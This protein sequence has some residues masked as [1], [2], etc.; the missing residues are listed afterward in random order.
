MYRKIYELLEK[1]GKVKSAVLLNGKN[2]GK[3]TVFSEGKCIGTEE[4]Q[5]LWEPY[6]A[7]VAKTEETTIIKVG[8]SEIFVEVYL[9]N[10]RLVILGAGHVS[11]PVAKIGKML[12][13]HI[14]VMDDRKEFLNRERFPDADVFICG[15]FEEMSERIPPYENTYY[16]VVTRGHQGDTVCARQILKRPH[17]YFGMIGSRNKVRLA[18][19]LLLQEGFTEEQLDSVYA[20]IGLPIGGQLPEEIAVSIAAQIVQVKNRNY[21]AFTDEKIAAAVR[22]GK[23]GIMATIIQKSGSSPRGIGSKMLICSPKECYGSI[24]GGS[25]EYEATKEA[26]SVDG[27]SR[28]YYNLSINDEKNLGMIC[29]GNVEILFEKV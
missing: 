13:F 17:V 12:G 24:G 15:S 20:P 29:G 9:K 27:T 1:N 3:R 16:V 23:N 2:I 8:E 5:R 14:T 10:P 18:R 11:V 26:E 7:A 4:E 22:E 19:E 28:R 21:A 6:E 25:V